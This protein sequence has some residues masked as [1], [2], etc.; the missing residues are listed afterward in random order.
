MPPSGRSLVRDPEQ[1]PFPLSPLTPLLP[2]P[3]ASSALELFLQPSL[4]TILSHLAEL[5]F[6]ASALRQHHGERQVPRIFS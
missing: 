6:Y 4:A 1:L 3:R 5:Q 2:D